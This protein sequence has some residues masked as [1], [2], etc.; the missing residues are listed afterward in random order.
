MSL[1][2]L[3]LC[4]A[5]APAPEIIVRLADGDILVDAQA[6]AVDPQD[7]VRRLAAGAAR[8]IRGE[9]LLAGRP[10]IEIHLAGRPIE[11]VL[12]SLGHATRTRIE[13][14]GR[15]ITIA[16]ER[17]LAE[18]DDLQYDA[19]HAW[20]S[21]V[22]EFPDHE[23]ARVARVELGAAQERRGHADAALTHYDA[24]TRD[25]AS[26]PA[27]E[28]ALLA[29]GELLMRRGEWNEAL[30]RFSQLAQSSPDQRTQASARIAVARALA[31]QGR[32]VEALALVDV[33]DLSYPSRGAA[34]VAERRQARARGHLAAGAPAEALRELDARAASDPRLA[35]DF[36]DLELRA[37]ALEELGSPR[38]AARAWLACATVASVANGDERAEALHAAARLS[39][40]AGDDIAVLFIER[41]ARGGT[42]AA[43]ISYYA[44]GARARLGLGRDERDLGF[45]EERWA[46]RARISPAER[47]A[48]AVDVV[49]AT[50]RERGASA[51]ADVA[52]AALDEVPAAAGRAIR[53]ALAVAYENEGSWAEAARVWGGIAP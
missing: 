30:R 4:A 8:E 32:G 52:R 35:E 44:D 49:A 26:S 48:L 24:A 40:G 41:L 10:R 17:T 38:E 39:A 20:V 5:Q 46:Q 11:D 28:R 7:F 47:A 37:R 42:R 53:S 15:A 16:P 43:D 3:L 12:A 14:D 50:A 1:A 29:A 25:G 9:D 23:A 31:E 18:A 21:L 33:V 6:A 34:D 27:A 51:A 19:E 36:E 45:L 22:R 2:A 13:L